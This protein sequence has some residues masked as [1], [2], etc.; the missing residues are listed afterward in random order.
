MPKRPKPSTKQLKSPVTSGK[1]NQNTQLVI[2]YKYL[3][4]NSKKYNMEELGS[5]TLIIQFYNEFNKKMLEYSS[6]ENFKKHI[7]DNGRY[8]DINH[9]HPIDWK[10]SRIRENCFTN[11]REDLMD[12]V[13]NDCWQ[14]GI[15]STTFR[16]HGFFI[17]NVFY[18]VWLDPLHK[19]YKS[20]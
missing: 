3:E 13:K 20:K 17:E 15:N 1:T 10:D 2:S 6:Y 16:V 18:I 19:L 7:N 12:Q 14:L 4:L 8:R 5:N 9:I 11:L